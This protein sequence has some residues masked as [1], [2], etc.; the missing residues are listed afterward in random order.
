MSTAT[1]Q[2][3]HRKA[4]QLKWEAVEH[5]AYSPDLA[6]YDFHLFRPLK[7]VLRGRRFSCDDVKAAVHHWLRAQLKTFFLMTLKSW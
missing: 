1:L 7:E 2:L 3:K 5:P 6:P 4:S